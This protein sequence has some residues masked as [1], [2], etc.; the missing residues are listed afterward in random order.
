M[1]WIARQVTF[2]RFVMSSNHITSMPA[3]DE[4][5]ER[6]RGVSNDAERISVLYPRILDKLAGRRL[7]G[8]EIAIGLSEAYGYFDL[9]W[10]T[11]DY[12]KY[13][14]A[15]IGDDSYTNPVYL[16]AY[17]YGLHSGRIPRVRY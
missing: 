16:D 12:E 4:M 15:L 11:V 8:R 17:E 5:L 14:A 3:R 7:S 2:R 6:L 10:A 1:R 13:L 9:G